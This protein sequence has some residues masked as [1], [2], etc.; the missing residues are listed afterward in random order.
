M[1]SSGR[2]FVTTC[3]PQRTKWGPWQTHSCS[4]RFARFITVRFFYRHFLGQTM[5]IHVGVGGSSSGPPATSAAASRPPASRWRSATGPEEDVLLAPRGP[6]RL[7]AGAGQGR[8]RGPCA[9]GHGGALV[10]GPHG[11]DLRVAGRALDPVDARPAQA[12]SPLRRLPDRAHL[13]QVGTGVLNLPLGA[14][15][16]GDGAPLGVGAAAL[17]LLVG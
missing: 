13:L 2:P 17:P 1:T 7:P 16:D 3:L 6:A 4:A 8:P 15:A 12:G 5:T 10:L 14:A 11:R 9:E